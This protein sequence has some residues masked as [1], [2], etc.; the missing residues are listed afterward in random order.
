MEVS[1]SAHFAFSASSFQRRNTLPLQNDLI[2][3]NRTRGV[4]HAF[5]EF[6]Y[7]MSFQ[8]DRDA[9]RLHRTAKLKNA[10]FTIQENDVD[11]KMHKETVNCLAGQDPDCF[12][13]WRGGATKPTLTASLAIVGGD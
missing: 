3:G 1:V 6:H 7:R 2:T 4:D 13:K 12:F 9:P 5:G 10:K 11:R 8:A